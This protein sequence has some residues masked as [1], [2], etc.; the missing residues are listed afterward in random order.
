MLFNVYLQMVFVDLFL[1]QNKIYGFSSVEKLIT[2]GLPDPPNVN[3]K[4]P[5]TAI[6]EQMATINGYGKVCTT[7]STSSTTV[8][9]LWI[10]T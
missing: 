6:H 5:N 9:P 1:F 10:I 8:R 4:P 2:C 3:T 7:T